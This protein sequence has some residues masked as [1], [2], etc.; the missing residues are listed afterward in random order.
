[1]YI[2]NRELEVLQFI[3]DRLINVHNEKE[4]YDYM[5]DFKK[6]L[7]VSHLLK[8]SITNREFKGEFG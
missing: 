7:D 6:I 3:Y 5:I 8:N 1:M 4:D 2:T